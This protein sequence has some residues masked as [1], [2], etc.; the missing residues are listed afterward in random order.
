VRRPA[1]CG[2]KH[3]TVVTSHRVHVWTSCLDC[4]S[5]MTACVSV[6]CRD[7][8]PPTSPTSTGRTFL[9]DGFIPRAPTQATTRLRAADPSWPDASL[10]G[11]SG[12]CCACVAGV[13]AAGG[14]GRPPLLLA[15]PLPLPLP[16]GVLTAGGCLRH[17][18]TQHNK[19]DSLRMRH[20][21]VVDPARITQG[22]DD[23]LRQDAS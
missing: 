3:A 23:H 15:L 7:D 6:P 20:T 4:H 18:S 19:H 9:S 12:C 22:I 14:A 21:S 16:V 13:L 17:N 2:W 10:A 8:C 5:S 11:G 1:S